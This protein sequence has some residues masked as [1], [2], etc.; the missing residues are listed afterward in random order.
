MNLIDGTK[1]GGHD[2]LLDFG[3]LI[4]E[5]SCSELRDKSGSVR[6]QSS[7]RLLLILSIFYLNYQ[8]LEGDYIG[9]ACIQS[10]L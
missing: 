4:Q 1:S 7:E 2:Q 5:V 3:K 9:G 8:K 10:A 6:L